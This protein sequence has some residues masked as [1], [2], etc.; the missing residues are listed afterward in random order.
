M[1]IETERLREE[2]RESM[3]SFPIGLPEYSADPII[4]RRVGRL[5]ATYGSAQPV[6]A[7]IADL[8]SDDANELGCAG[9]VGLHSPRRLERFA[10]RTRCVASQH[11]GATSENQNSIG[12]RAV[13]HSIDFGRR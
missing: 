1:T 8:A 4:Q 11:N 2:F 13:L 12:Q 3:K 9:S 5:L 10:L 6:W 7:A